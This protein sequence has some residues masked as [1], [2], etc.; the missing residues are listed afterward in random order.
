MSSRTISN[1]TARRAAERQAAKAAA[2]LQK[3]QQNQQPTDQAVAATPVVEPEAH[4]QVMSAAAGAAAPATPTQGFTE[5]STH[6]T[7]PTP[8][9]QLSEAQLNANRAN[10]QKSHGPVTPE[11]RAKSSL[12]AVKTGLTGQTVLLPTDDAIAY[13]AHLDRHFK[14]DSPA[15]D[16]E[17]TLVQMIADAEW[18]ILR[19]PSLE[20]SIH[21]LGMLKFADLHAEQTDPA[22]RKSLITGEILMAYRRD[23]TNLA[24]Q[25]RRLRNQ[26]KSDQAK[27]KALQD[28]RI[29]RTEEKARIQ[30]R[31][32]EAINYM[33]AA[34]K[35][36]GKFVPIEFGFE[37]SLDEIEYCN[38][39]LQS[40][41]RMS[42]KAPCIADLL[43]SRRKNQKQ[44][45]AA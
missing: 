4:P 37:F 17:H 31:M 7:E 1:R 34:K 16:Q 9:R 29:H 6:E 35:V 30:N 15:T 11:G 40:T 14:Q 3:M 39:I 23:L 33:H 27:L 5:E 32:N 19:I 21:A 20:A 43:A 36:W 38:E 44:A 13:Q 25:E 42:L 45:Q 22:V 18:R 2:K 8:I 41:H 28:E 10:A 26:M 24:L 12:N